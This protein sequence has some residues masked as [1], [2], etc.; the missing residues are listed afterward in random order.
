MIAILTLSGAPAARLIQAQELGP[1]GRV[2]QGTALG[3]AFTYQGRLTDAGGNPVAGPCALRFSL[4]QS[5]AGNDPVG[6]PITANGVTP[7]NGYFSVDL[8]FGAGAFTGDARFLKV[9]VDCGGGFTTL[10]PRVRLNPAPYALHSVSTGALRGR[11]VSDSAPADGDV[12][13]WD[14]SSWRPTA[15]TGSAQYANVLV[16]AQSGGNYTSI[17]G[18]LDSITDADWNNR[19]LVWVAPGVY[20]ER[21]TMKPY[22]DIEGAGEWV[23]TITYG[24]SAAADTGTILS[25]S[26]AAL[27]FL[28]VRNTGGANIAVAIYN[29][30]ASPDILHVTAV[31]NE[32]STHNIG[33]FNQNGALPKMTYVSVTVYGASGTH[34][35]AVV[36]QTNV[37]S[38]LTHV[39]VDVSGGAESV[40]VY[41]L[42]NSSPTL[43][44]V[45][46]WASNATTNYGLY[47]FESNATVRD[48][49]IR[50]DTGTNRYGVY[51]KWQSSGGPYFVNIDNS[52]IHLGL[53]TDTTIRS[54]KWFITNLG[55]SQ[56]SGGPVDTSA[57]GT[58]RC[59]GC[60]DEQYQNAGGVGVCP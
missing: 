15:P 38:T 55:A 24:G 10:D 39:T 42:Y 1:S 5:A 41:N 31:A 26:G 58:V 9:E 59:Y 47:N 32:G 12:L 7:D 54:D 43:V 14:G 34:N 45:N 16:V 25:A 44:N 2:I 13:A 17:Q 53:N 40:G 29:D 36:N 19:Y 46:I 30:N 48:S 50:A 28:T 51:N 52:L 27:R 8:D 22:V 21:V 33:V 23:T 6:A 11:Q 18:A 37:F 4:Y 20:T 35:W 3:T 49:I 60:Y 57:G 56:L